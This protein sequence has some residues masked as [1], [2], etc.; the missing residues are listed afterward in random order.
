MLIRFLPG[1]C[2]H[3][4]GL[5]KGLLFGLNASTDGVG[6]LDL[7]AVSSARKQPTLFFSTEGMAREHKG[8]SQ[9]LTHQGANETGVGVMGMNPIH[10]LP[11]SGEVMH[12]LVGE[13]L[14]IGPKQF[15]PEITLGT[16][17]ETEN[18]R[19]RSN[20]LLRATV[21]SSNPSILNQPG[22]H[23]DAIHLGALGKAPNKIEH[24]K[25]LTT[26]IGITTKLKITG[27]EQTMQMQM[28]HSETRS[29]S[30]DLTQTTEDVMARPRFFFRGG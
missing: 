10:P 8:D 4:I 3:Q 20:R 11:R 12:E 7:L 26:G 2:D 16:K 24:V 6:L 25:R 19:S 29:H 28:Q 27:T 1:A 17:A 9:P 5:R 30:G 13:I 21:V 18:A 22:H 15:L 14:Q 23:I